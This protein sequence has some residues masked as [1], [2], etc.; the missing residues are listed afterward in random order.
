MHARRPLTFLSLMAGGAL[1]LAACGSSSASSG[2]SPAAPV[3]V[4]ATSTVTATATATV[5]AVATPK[6]AH[7]T[8]EGEEG[9][10]HWADLDPAYSACGTGKAQ[11]PVDIS[12]V[13]VANLT[14]PVLSY[15]SG[16]AEIVNNG[17]TVQANAAEGSSMKVGASV[18]PLAQ[19]HFHTP[20]ENTLDGVH[21][22][23][24]LHFVHKTA[25]GKI[26]VLGVMLKAGKENP[27]Y[28]PLVSA[29]KTPKDGTTNVTLDW[30]ALVPADFSTYRFEGSLT[31]PPCT[32]GVHWFVVSE[33]VSV[34]QEQIDAF[35][36]AYSDNNRPVQALN[37]RTVVVG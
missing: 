36:A 4:T 23:V 7:W 34:S 22:A 19:V 8:Y 20:S 27:A 18:Y 14:P 16:E 33:P 15:K 2:A 31:T 12:T 35:E 25:D 30:G 17:H 37:G 26:A 13:K 28:A 6:L 21:D 10:T 3:T 29:L 11:S 1:L 32:E 9:P 24:E 5:T